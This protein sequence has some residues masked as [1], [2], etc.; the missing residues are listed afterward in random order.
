MLSA[1]TVLLDLDGTV[2]DSRSG[3]EASCRAALK[4]LGHPSD[5]LDLSGLIGPPIED[6]M[7]ALLLPFNDNRI[8]QGVAAY[9]ADYGSSGLYGSVLYDG[10]LDALKALRRADARLM[11][12]TSKRRRFAIRILDH[13]G[14]SDLFEATY[15]SDEAGTLDHKPELLAHIIDRES[16]E[17]R[18]CVMIGDRRHDIAGARANQMKSLGVLWGYGSR[19]ELETAGATDIVATPDRLPNVAL[20]LACE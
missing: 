8:D 16:L 5:V 14:L 1:T 13:L 10:I 15:G 4:A 20:S 17:P 18:H 9:R 19:K 12:A 11:I 6:I 2:V 3:I 7:R